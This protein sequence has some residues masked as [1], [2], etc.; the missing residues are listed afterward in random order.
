M[1]T[2]TL[3]SWLKII[4]AHVKTHIVN[5][6]VAIYHKADDLDDFYTSTRAYATRYSHPGRY[7]FLQ[8]SGVNVTSYISSILH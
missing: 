7:P 8:T 3:V 6:V 5:T 2:I 4:K 1:M